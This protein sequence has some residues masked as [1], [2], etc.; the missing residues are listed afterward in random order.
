MQED[1]QKAIDSGK[2]T[3][4]AGA[5]LKKLPPGTC[6]MH[7]SWGFGQ[8]SGYDFILN[9]T[10][11]DF[12]GRKGHPM[13]MQ[14]AAE[15]LTLVEPG[16][17]LSRKLLD[18]SQV[19]ALAKEDPVA[20]SRVV[21]ESFGGKAT[22]DQFASVLVPDVMAES[23]FK[24]WIE[25]ARKAMK[26]DG[27]F[28]I[29]T[30]KVL[31][32]ELRD[33]PISHADEYL[34]KFQ[35][36]RQLKDQIEALDLIVKHVAEFTDAPTTLRPVIEA[37]NEA[38]RKSMRLHTSQ[39][40][41]LLL[42]RDELIEK[43][44]GLE[45]G[46]NAPTVGALLVEEQRD[47]PTLC[48][49]VPAAKMKRVLAELPAAFGDDW[50]AKAVTLVLRGKA[51]VV[52]E[53]ARLL[54]ERGRTD[55][56]SNAINRALSEHSITTDALQWLCNEREGALADLVDIRVLHASVSA[57]ERDQ[58]NEKKD[59]KL[60]DLLVNDQDLVPDLISNATS[61]ELRDTMRKLLLTP[62][63]EELNKRSLLGRIVRIRPELQSMITGDGASEKSENDTGLI[64]S[65]ESLERKRAEFEDLVKRKIPE[66]VKEIQIARSY[67][68]LRENFEFKAAKEMQRVL[69]RRRADMERDLGRARGT[70]FS[71]VD[72]SAVNIGTTVTL[73]E[74]GNGQ[75]DV[76]TLLGAWDTVP[77]AGIIS[78][79]SALAAALFGKKV[80]DE[81]KAPT[82]HGDRTVV[83]EKIQPAQH[84]PA[85]FVAREPVEAT[86]E[87]ASV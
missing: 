87:E 78:Y 70:D 3:A 80:G 63:F 76:Y 39:A 71:N 64:V 31:P 41:S 66:N 14:Y 46:P 15:S 4:A 79:Q 25:T 1:I 36:A 12:R 50:P 62:V 38:A 26:A 65:W 27:H 24:K 52:A 30:K 60:H 16:H 13:Q 9:Q 35:S 45:L 69:G 5:A 8:I 55:E 32:F 33:G 42:S 77:E 81:L 72:T 22:H 54:V 21:L 86:P 48:N 11:I 85:P 53:T 17:I 56:L 20:L 23:A 47:L 19:K 67:G 43:V 34:A 37:A 57:L 74:I 28:A 29:P 58:F 61:E 10:T 18:L 68:D 40:L 83:V 82:E 6:V 44:E 84:K 49:G 2:L 51:R 75:I 7:K 59:R 73:R